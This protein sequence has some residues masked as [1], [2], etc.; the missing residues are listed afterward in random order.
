MLGKVQNSKVYIYVPYVSTYNL[1]TLMD[2][3][4]S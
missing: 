4:E 1:R 2:E 3:F